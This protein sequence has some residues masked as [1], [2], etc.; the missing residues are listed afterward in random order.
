[1]PLG[2][3]AGRTVPVEMAR[4]AC[5]SNPGETSAMWIRDR[6]NEPV[7]DDDFADWFPADGRHGLS[8]VVL[9]SLDARV[10]R[11]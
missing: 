11:S 7:V 1:M 9:A 3:G 6:L 4:A 2:R 10:T 8:P 5:A